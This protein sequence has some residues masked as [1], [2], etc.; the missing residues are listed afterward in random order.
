MPSIRTDR[1]IFSYQKHRDLTNHQQIHSVDCTKYNYACL[2]DSKSCDF[3][4]VPKLEYLRKS[5]SHAQIS[6]LYCEWYMTNPVSSSSLSKTMR[7]VTRPLGNSA[8]D[9]HTASAVTPS[10]FACLNHYHKTH[11]Q[12]LTHSRPAERMAVPG[13]MSGMA[14]FDQYRSFQVVLLCIAPSRHP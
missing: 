13:E 6:F 11:Q 4:D 14:R 10:A 8:V 1:S 3:L 12:T 7:D 9:K 5:T 2:F